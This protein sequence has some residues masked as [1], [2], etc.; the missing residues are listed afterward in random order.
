[1]AAVFEMKNEM[2]IEMK[3]ESVTFQETTFENPVSSSSSTSLYEF[4]EKIGEGSSASVYIAT[5]PVHGENLAVKIIK[6]KYDRSI[7]EYE[8]D[9]LTR[10]QG[11]P[12]VTKVYDSWVNKKGEFCIAMERVEYSLYDILDKGLCLYN[13]FILIKQIAEG[14]QYLHS[15]GVVHC[16]IKPDNIGVVGFDSQYLGGFQIKLLDFGLSQDLDTFMTPDF[17]QKLSSGQIGTGSTF[18]RAYESALGLPQSETI[19]VW[20]LGCMIY[21]FFNPQSLFE[22]MNDE[23]TIAELKK[24]FDGCL[25]VVASQ[26]KLMCSNISQKTKALGIVMKLCFEL[27]GAKRVSAGTIFSFLQQTEFM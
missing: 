17:Q 25:N 15:K 18:Y 22:E 13:K 2:T 21:D 3:S 11:H 1:M 12:S 20:A 7:G 14:L 10:L 26:S 27:D 5:H 6:A 8:F 19:D 4:G 23:M 9:V 24:E 16:D